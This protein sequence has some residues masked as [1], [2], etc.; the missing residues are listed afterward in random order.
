VG[1]DVVVEEVAVDCRLNDSSD[2]DERVVVVG[3]GH[4]AV[5]PVNQ[6]H[7]TVS[8]KGKDVVGSKIL[9]ETTRIF[10]EIVNNEELR[11]NSDGLEVD[12]EGPKH[13][14]YGEVFVHQESKDGA[15]DE[16]VQDLETIGLLVIGITVWCF[17]CHEE[18]NSGRS[19]EED[20]LHNPVV[21]G[22]KVVEEVDITG[23]K[24][25]YI[26]TLGLE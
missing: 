12:R 5:D 2:P 17:E 13:F 25:K 24:D 8:T 18:D 15:G 4:V 10:G 22:V 19:D 1:S 16:E 20:D 14:K 11:Y 23:Q 26:Q 7:S 3:L 9:D 21:H 6:V